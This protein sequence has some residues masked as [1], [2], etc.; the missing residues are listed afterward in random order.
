MDVATGG[1]QTWI[2]V[3]AGAVLTVGGWI[4]SALR[5]DHKELRRDHA[6]L[7]DSLPATYAR[8]D[9]VRDALTEMKQAHKEMNAKLDR[10]L[11]RQ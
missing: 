7:V 11:E 3:A 4:L 10:L 8:R 1:A 5:S 9:D 2:D 6:D